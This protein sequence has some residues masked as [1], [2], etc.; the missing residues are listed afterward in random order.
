VKLSRRQALAMLQVSFSA[1]VKLVNVYATVRDGRGSV[2]KDL[3]QEDFEVY[4]DERRQTIRYFSP[5]T[6]VPLRLGLVVDISGSMARKVAAERDACRR[7]FRQV[8]R[9]EQ[10]RAFLIRFD[11]NVEIVQ[12]LTGMQ[13]A[14]DKAAGELAGHAQWQRERL[15]ARPG[16]TAACRSG[17]S[18]L[19]D[20]VF[21]ASAQILQKERGRKALIVL[22]DGLDLGSCVTLR[23]T[24]EAAQRADAIVYT[25]LFLESGPARTAKR[26]G[27]GSYPGRALMEQLASR[28]G[29]RMFIPGIDSTVP[30]AF[31]AIEEE[32][33]SQYS[34]GYTSDAPSPG[35]HQL[36]VSAKGYTVQAREGYY[37]G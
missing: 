28:T 19:K 23:N 11:Q 8:L 15:L 30:K 21:A 36:R 6:N 26:E 3:K 12:G 10:D 32:L 20:A 34:I 4:E 37:G 2:I 13:A 25:M 16:E 14:L 17:T 35:F 24:V 5:E 1:D 33:R 31:A 22:S 7:F 18:A 29:G 27:L 9:P